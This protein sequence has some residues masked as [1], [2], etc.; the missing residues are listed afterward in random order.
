M[1]CFRLLFVLV[2]RVIGQDGGGG[3]LNSF[4]MQPMSSEGGM[5]RKKVAAATAMRCAAA[6]RRDPAGAAAEKPRCSA[7]AVQAV[8]GGRSKA[9]LSWSTCLR[10]ARS[11]QV[12]GSAP[13]E[14]VAAV[15]HGGTRAVRDQRAQTHRW[16]SGRGDRGAGVEEGWRGEG[17]RA[18]RGTLGQA[19][20]APSD[21]SSVTSGVPLCL[22]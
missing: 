14:V 22:R 8:D 12:K 15:K 2:W 18:G 9:R 5:P 21:L 19:R 11:P 13:E 1:I 7:A 4:R 16:L 3:A 10:R 17:R 20:R 6:S